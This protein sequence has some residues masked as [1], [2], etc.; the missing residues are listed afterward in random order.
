[1]KYLEDRFPIQLGPFTITPFLVDHSAYD[2]YAILIDAEGKRIFY[3][4]DFRGHGRKASLIDRL[5]DDPP[6]NVDILLMEGTCIGRDD[7]PFPT[8]DELIP[9]FVDVF[10]KTQ[11]MPFVWCSGQNIDRI[12][13]IFKAC[14][15]AG[16]HFIIDMYTA[17]ILRATGNDRLPQAKWDSI[18]VFLP[19]SQKIRVIQTQSF[20]ISNSYKPNR[21]YDNDIAKVAS[22]SV[23]LFR[24]NMNRDLEKVGCL[25]GSCVVN[26]VWAGYLESEKNQWFA[27]WMKDREIPLHL[28]HTSGHASISDL[29]RMRNAFPDALAVPVHLEDP[30]RF[31]NLFNNVQLH[32]DGD[33]WEV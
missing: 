6:K 5:I 31:T 21:I 8:E 3:T 16:R 19:L 13:T 23:M 2:S 11:G 14:R 18:S 26:S 4:G 25:E 27:K 9:K 22:E 20:H 15:R 17:E 10:K 28:I 29:R 12:L 7:K 30:E 1:M 33:W 32:D 24:P